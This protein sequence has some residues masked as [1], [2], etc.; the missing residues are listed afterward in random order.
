MTYET[1]ATVKNSAQQLYTS[2]SNDTLIQMISLMKSKPQTDDLKFR[3]SAAQTILDHRKG[4][5]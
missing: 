1:A 2:L 5:K 4:A 3:V